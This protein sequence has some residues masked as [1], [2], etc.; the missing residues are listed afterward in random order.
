MQALLSVNDCAH[1]LGISPIT[2]RLYVKQGK[3]I[4]IRIGKRVLF[5]TEEVERFVNEAK[6]LSPGNLREM[7][8]R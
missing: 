2:V 1:I 4:P 7:G 5:Q 6:A 3:L 8:A